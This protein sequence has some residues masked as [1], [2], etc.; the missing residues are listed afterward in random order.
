LARAATA[1]LTHEIHIAA[2][3]DDVDAE[4]PRLLAGCDSGTG[5]APLPIAMVSP[6]ALTSA[7]RHGLGIA[8]VVLTSASCAGGCLDLDLDFCLFDASTTSTTCEGT[9]LVTTSV[10]SCSERQTET[11]MDC[12]SQ[13]MACLP[14]YGCAIPCTTDRECPTGDYCDGTACQEDLPEGDI[15][16]FDSGPPCAPGLVCQPVSLASLYEA[17]LFFR[18]LKGARPLVDDA[19]GAD[20]GTE[21]DAAVDD[22]D[23]ADA[24]ATDGALGE[25]A[26]G[27][28]VTVGI[29][30]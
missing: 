11:R 22:G 8:A 26:A 19:A 17:G 13:G 7:A 27:G 14:D 15:C 16:N 30:Q 18:P 10:D 24:T 5:I 12:A 28:G 3:H 25:A 20:G 1:R 23:A 21:V 9:V 6:R 4:G 29:C 2:R